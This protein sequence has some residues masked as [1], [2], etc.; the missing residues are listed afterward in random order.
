M[1]AATCVFANTTLEEGFLKANNDAVTSSSKTIEVVDTLNAMDHSTLVSI[2][3]DD[4]ICTV[5]VTVTDGERTVS[6]RATS[7]SGDCKAA[8]D[9]ATMKALEEYYA[10]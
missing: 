7:N 5:T 6:V 9:A 10:L 4:D 8:E 3:Y 2:E 1:L